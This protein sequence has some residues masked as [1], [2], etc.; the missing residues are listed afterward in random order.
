[1]TDLSS[2]GARTA[3]SSRRSRACQSD[4]PARIRIFKA[5]FLTFDECERLLA[6]SDPW[7]TL[8]YKSADFHKI[9]QASRGWENVKAAARG[10][11]IA[12]SSFQFG[13]MRGGYV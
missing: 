11:T 8:G 9:A 7:R 5:S 10:Q 12:F 1:M 13:F 4:P 6:A 2:R 3:P